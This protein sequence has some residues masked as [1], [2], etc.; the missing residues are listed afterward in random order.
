VVL[1]S[2]HPGVTA[3]QILPLARAVAAAL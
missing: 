1:F 3:E 2:L